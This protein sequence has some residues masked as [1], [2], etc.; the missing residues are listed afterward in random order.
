MMIW[1]SSK[2]YRYDLQSS[3][4]T[5]VCDLERLRYERRRT[6]SFGSAEKDVY[7]FN[8]IPYTESLVSITD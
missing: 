5:V 3:E 2:L 1:L 7:F 4:L 8:V 6:G